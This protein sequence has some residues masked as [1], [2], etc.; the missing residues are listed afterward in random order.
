MITLSIA[1]WMPL[2]R[3][4]AVVVALG[5]L[6]W[7]GWSYTAAQRAALIALEQ[8][9][10]LLPAEQAQQAAAEEGLE[11]HQSSF[12]R[13]QTFV[14]AA[15]SIPQFIAALETEAKKR[16]VTVQVADVREEEFK[17]DEGNVV[18]PTGPL[19]DIRLKAVAVGEPVQLVDF[20]RAVENVPY[21]GRVV[22]WRLNA[23]ATGGAGTITATIPTGSPSSAATPRGGEMNLTFLLSIRNET[24]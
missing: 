12:Q 10:E 11:K 3:R 2:L 16:G 14:V 5:A 7:W 24:P 6:T 20:L 17:D 22:D 8:R 18:Q 4:V 21:L 1:L 23:V 9:L 19:R 13:L 15:E